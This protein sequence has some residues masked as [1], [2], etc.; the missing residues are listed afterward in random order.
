MAQFLHMQITPLHFYSPNKYLR[1]L[2]LYLL[3]KMSKKKKTKK[4]TK[5]KKTKNKTKQNKKQQQQQLKMS[6]GIYKEGVHENEP[7]QI[8]VTRPSYMLPWTGPSRS[9]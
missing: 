6:I 8:K 1:S 3:S 5:K 4:K 2:G 9:M 7:L